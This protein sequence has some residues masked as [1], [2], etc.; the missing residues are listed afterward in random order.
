MIIN[1]FKLNIFVH[2]FMWCYYNYRELNYQY[3]I[4]QFGN[5]AKSQPEQNVVIKSKKCWFFR[6][7]TLFQE[8]HYKVVTLDVTVPYL[9]YCITAVNKQ[10]T[11]IRK[12]TNIIAFTWCHILMV[13]TFTIAGCFIVTK[14]PFTAAPL[15]CVW[16]AVMSQKHLMYAGLP[17]WYL[18]SVSCYISA[19]CPTEWRMW[20]CWVG[21]QVGGVP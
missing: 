2:N 17:I 14:W 5:C 9:S 13:T 19:C 6:I 18:Y 10:S 7:L 8:E 1:R 11:V 12:V 21:P 4:S 16:P 20:Y 3:P 15:A